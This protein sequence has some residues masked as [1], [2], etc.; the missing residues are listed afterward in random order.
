LKT[1]TR[2]LKSMRSLIEYHHSCGIAHYSSTPQVRSGLEALERCV[3][4]AAESKY[5]RTETL[6]KPGEKPPK[7]EAV[8]GISMEELTA[9]VGGCR[10]CPLHESRM[11]STAGRGGKSPHLLIVGDWLVHGP[12]LQDDGLFGAEQ[13]RMLDNMI[14]ALGLAP[15]DVFVTNIIKCSVG[16]SYRAATEHLA[17]C[18]SYLDQQIA[19]LRPAVICTMGSVSSQALLNTEDSLI[20]LRGEFHRYR[21]ADGSFISVMP[22]F[23]PTYL[24]KNPEMKKPTWSDLQKIGKFLAQRR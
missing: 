6:P 23:H 4:G 2:L 3:S 14:H 18:S 13:D 19:L 8:G 17:A 1:R 15:G 5:I 16:A 22:T 21:I 20:S 10:I 11:T 7:P 9:E 12:G 24:L